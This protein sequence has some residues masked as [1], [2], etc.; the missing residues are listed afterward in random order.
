MRGESMKKWDKAPESVWDLPLEEL[1]RLLTEQQKRFVAEL[2]RDGKPAE[3]AKRAGYSEKTAE[4]QASRLLKNVKI[5]AY[6]RARSIDLYKRQGITPEWVG[7][8]LLEIY[9]RCMEA[10]PH[11]SWDREARAWMPDGTWVFDAKGA[12]NAIG[13]IGESMGMFRPEKKQAS[14]GGGQTVEEYLKGLGSGRKF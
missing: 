3:A 14:E 13:K 2:E 5:A 1:E 8:E 7:N 4:S 12:L 6:R 9:R 11:F 10:E